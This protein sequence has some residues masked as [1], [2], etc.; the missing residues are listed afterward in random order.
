MTRLL[1]EDDDDSVEQAGE[2]EGREVGQET[3]LKV[4]APDGEDEEEA[5]YEAEGERDAE[6]LG[7]SAGVVW[8]W[9]VGAWRQ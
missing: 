2:G 9:A 5:G 7:L 1:G 8:A 4:V 3:G 6:E